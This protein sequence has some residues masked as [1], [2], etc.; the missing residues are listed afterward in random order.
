MQRWQIFHAYD[1]RATAHPPTL[2]QESEGEEGGEGGVLKM[3]YWITSEETRLLG[4]D[5]RVVLSRDGPVYTFLDLIWSDTSWK[6]L[7][8]HI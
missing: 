1:I 3:D 2:T 6:V 4:S 7:L 5:A 8:S